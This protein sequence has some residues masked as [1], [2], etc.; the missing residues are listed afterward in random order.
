MYESKSLEDVFEV[1]RLI[2]GIQDISQKSS[3]PQSYIYNPNIFLVFFAKIDYT[4][5]IES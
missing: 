4:I 5:N 3:P 1:L 2:E